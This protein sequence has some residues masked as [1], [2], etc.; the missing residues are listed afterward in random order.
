[1]GVFSQIYSKMK[2]IKT[3]LQ[4]TYHENKYILCVLFCDCVIVIF[5]VKN[6]DFSELQCYLCKHFFFFNLAEWKFWQSYDSPN[7]YFFL[8]DDL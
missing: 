7:F 6:V 5:G 2:K 1:M 8:E 4:W 3:E